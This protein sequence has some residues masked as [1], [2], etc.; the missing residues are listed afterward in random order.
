MTVSDISGDSEDK[1][2]CFTSFKI[3]NGGTLK[4]NN[5]KCAILSRGNI[6]FTGDGTGATL[7]LKNCEGYEQIEVPINATITPLTDGKANIRWTQNDER[8]LQDMVADG[9]GMY[10][11]YENK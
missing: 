10:N 9:Y 8:T 11:D 7:T 5:I 6:F 2:E 4:M 3:E 1:S